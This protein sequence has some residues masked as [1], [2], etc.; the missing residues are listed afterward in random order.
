MFHKNEI[1]KLRKT[2]KIAITKVV[3]RLKGDSPL[4]LTPKTLE[5]SA[6]QHP[7]LIKIDEQLAENEMLVEYLTKIENNFR[8]ISYD[9]KN[10]ID[11][12]RLETT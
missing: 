4:A 3:D 12:V 11:I 6:E 8:S 7:L 9:I 2:R 1:A 10:L 5:A